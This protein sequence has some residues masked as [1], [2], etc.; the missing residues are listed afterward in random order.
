[1]TDHNLR[2]R[3]HSRP[4]DGNFDATEL[5]RRFEQMLSTKRLT[6][7][8]DRSR[9]RS[10][11]PS[12]FHQSTSNRPLSTSSST[13]PSYSSLRN[14]PKVPTP[15]QD[16]TSLKFR[17]LLIAI[18]HTPLKYENPGLLD[19]ALQ[20]I[21]LERIYNEAEEESQI[22]QAQAASI[23]GNAKPE[24]GYQDCVIRSLLRYV[25]INLVPL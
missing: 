11:S 14:I 24:W 21:P 8:A 22:M 16:P 9:S 2:F 5:T 15:P 13:L 19:N 20:A 10:N 3:A 1:M 17:N 18:S 4:Q 25:T 12:P 7:L 6:E 23:G